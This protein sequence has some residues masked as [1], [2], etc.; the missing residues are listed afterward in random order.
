MEASRALTHTHTHTH[1]QLPLHA[2]NTH[3]C[4]RRDKRMWS[5]MKREPEDISKA[6]RA[7]L[8]HTGKQYTADT[9]QDVNPAALVITRLL[10]P[11]AV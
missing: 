5:K 10:G 4:G 7:D 2:L 9:E 1:R 6:M 3:K 8:P 11:C